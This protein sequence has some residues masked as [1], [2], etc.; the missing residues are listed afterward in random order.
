[1]S[2]S[3]SGHN[4]T[5]GLKMGAA[6]S[7]AEMASQWVP[8]S[9]QWSHLHFRIKDGCFHTW[10]FMLVLGIQTGILMFEQQT[11]SHQT[12]SQS[13]HFTTLCPQ[14]KA[15][16][17]CFVLFFCLFFL[18]EDRDCKD[19]LFSFQRWCLPLHKAISSKAHETAIHPVSSCTVSLPWLLFQLHL[20]NSSEL[21]H[22]VWE[23]WRILRTLSW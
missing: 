6:I 5:M 2:S 18:T 1:M 12:I 3:F 17:F 16:L 20:A 23:G 15:T 10:P 22:F 21:S 9:L 7:L 14:V 8:G 11:P 13:L 19:Y 4:S